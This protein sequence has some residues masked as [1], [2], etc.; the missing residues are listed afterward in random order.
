MI[1]AGFIRSRPVPMVRCVTVDLEVPAE[2]EFMLEGYVDP[3]ELRPKGRS[4]IIRDIIP[5]LGI[6]PSF[7]SRR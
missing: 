2:A 3:D 6:I 5:W 1:L 4:A 7:M